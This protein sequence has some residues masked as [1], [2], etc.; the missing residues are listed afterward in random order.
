VVGAILLA[1]AVV[2]AGLAGVVVAHRLDAAPAAS[3][4][5]EQGNHSDE[6]GDGQS[7]KAPAKAAKPAKPAHASP[8]PDDS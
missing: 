2:F 4:V 3:A 7:R 1:S 8:E 5:Q 6:Q